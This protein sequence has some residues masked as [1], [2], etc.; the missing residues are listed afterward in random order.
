MAIDPKALAAY[1]GKQNFK[2]SQR[3]KI[4]RM[5]GRDLA[6][7]HVHEYDRAA[8]FA[9]VPSHTEPKSYRPPNP[10]QNKPQALGDPE[11]NLQGPAYDNDHRNDWVRGR[12]QSG[13]GKPGFD[14]MQGR[15]PQPANPS[16]EGP[17]AR[18]SNYSPPRH[19]WAPERG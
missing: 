11:T 15:Q 9:G 10:N 7:V 13:E 17:G 2:D 1:G 5:V 6:K 16:G 12:G 8:R 3:T 18:R 19:G 4:E 14:K